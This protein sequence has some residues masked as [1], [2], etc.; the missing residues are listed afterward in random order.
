MPERTF[1]HGISSE[2]YGLKEE[3]HRRLAAPRV[4][5]AKEIPWEGGPSHWNKDVLRPDSEPFRTQTLDVHIESE[6]PGG[7]SHNHA[8]Q[9]EA[10][11]YVL[12]GRGH[13]IHDGER[14]EWEAGDLLVVHNES[15]HQ[16]C[17]DD[18]ERPSRFLIIKAKPLWMF[19][20]LIQQGYVSRAPTEDKGYRPKD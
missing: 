13:D 4:I 2:Q 15:L 16:H 17:N 14:Y 18:P 7:I 1:V 10:V 19:M 12:E 11:I 9:N 8:H 5:R 3:R 20:G 6:A